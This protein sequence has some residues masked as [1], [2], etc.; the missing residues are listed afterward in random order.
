MDQETKVTLRNLFKLVFASNKDKDKYSKVESF[1]ELD[2]ILAA[3]PE[4]NAAVEEAINSYT[5]EEL[6]SMAAEL[7]EEL[8]PVAKSGG[9]V[10]YLGK[11]Q[12]YKK[13]KKCK[14]GCDLIFSKEDG[15]KITQKCA[16]G[17]KQ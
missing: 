16:C 13:G 2:E 4:D 9:K 7:K 8:T 12:K 6:L 11:L 1:E 17:C 15:G 14:C 3:N 5:D 10:E